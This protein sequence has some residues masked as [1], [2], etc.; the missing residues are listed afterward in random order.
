MQ[1]KWSEYANLRRIQIET[2]KDIT[3]NKVFIPMFNKYIN[4]IK[5]DSALEV[6][7]GTG[8]MSKELIST[9]IKITAIEPSIG[10]YKVAEK[11]LQETNVVLKNIEIDKL[12]VDYK[13]D[14]V[15]SHLVVQCVKSFEQFLKSISKHL[16]HGGCF[17]FTI[18]HPCFFNEYKKVHDLNHNYMLPL[19]VEISF[20]I[21]LDTENTIS[22]VPYNHRPLSYYLNS[23]INAG[24]LIEEFIEVYP[25]YDIQKLYGTAWEKPRYCLFKCN[26]K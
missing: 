17:L 18:P 19:G 10:M 22:G 12:P 21:S 8:H 3:F 2:G 23:I 11:V 15:F 20:N 14:L 5:P 24:F 6:G 26:F 16:K 9:G 7:S 25:E 4:F 1:N 13:Y